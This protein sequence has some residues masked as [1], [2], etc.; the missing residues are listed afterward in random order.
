MLKLLLLFQD[1]DATKFVI[2]LI[3][4]VLRSRLDPLGVADKNLQAKELAF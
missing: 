1:T 2:I 4:F 3:R